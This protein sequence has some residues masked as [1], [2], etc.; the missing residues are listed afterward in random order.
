MANIRPDL[1]ITNPNG[2]LIASI[3]IKNMTNLSSQEATEIRRDLLEYGLPNQAPYFL[4]LSQDIGFLWKKT[5]SDTSDMPPTYEFPMNN[6][7]ERY[8]KRKTARRLYG[9]ELE[10]LVLQWLLNLSDKPQQ[11]FEEPEKTL[12]NSGFSKDIQGA[13][14]LLEQTA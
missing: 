2:D 11:E 1:V 12:A 7:I 9:S 13:S 5:G 14:V 10:L 6:I 4:L 8:L 3:E